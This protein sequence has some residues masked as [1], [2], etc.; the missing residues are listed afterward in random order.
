MEELL[1]VAHEKADELAKPEHDEFCMVDK[2]WL[3]GTTTAM[4]LTRIEEHDGK[5]MYAFYGAN[6]GDSEA[7]L[8]QN[9]KSYPLTTCHD[10]RNQSEHRRIISLGGNFVDLKYVNGK[11]LIKPECVCRCLSND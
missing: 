2:R 4:I 10:Y 8:V 5:R 9:G 6:V 3:Y 7:I 11:K 1:T